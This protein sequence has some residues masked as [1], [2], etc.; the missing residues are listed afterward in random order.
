MMKIPRRDLLLAACLS[1]YLIS[2]GG[3]GSSP[4]DTTTPE[5]GSASPT[6]DAEQCAVDVAV[7]TPALTI[8]GGDALDFVGDRF[9]LASGDFNGDGRDDL[10]IGAPL[11][12]GL[13]N[14]RENSGEAYVILG[15]DSPPSSID[16]AQGDAALTV[17][18]EASG[19]H[20]G[21]TVAAGDVNGDGTDDVL[22]GARFASSD[23]RGAA[24]KAYVIFGGADLDSTV[25]TATGQQDVTVVGIDTGD[26]LTVALATGDVDGDGVSDIIMGA[27]GASGPEED[28]HQAGEVYVL[29]GS[30]R[31]E[32][33]I[34]L[35]Q[36]PPFFTVYGA[37]VNDGLPNHLA[38]GDLDG[39]GDDELIVGGPFA[40]GA[41]TEENAGR[42]Y[43]AAV[44]AAG[45]S[46]DLAAAK[47]FTTL[48]GGSIRD[49]LGFYVSA[50]DINSDGLD[51][52]IIGAR[53]ADGPNEIR[54]NIG[55][56]HILY[57]GADIGSTIDLAGDAVDAVMYGVDPGDSSGFS[58]GAGDFNGDGI[59]DV[60][61]GAPTADGCQNGRAESG[62][63]RIRFGRSDFPAISDFVLGQ[64]DLSFFGLESG[65]EAG[66]SLA[67]GDFNGDEIDDVFIGA[68]LAD[69]PGNARRD[70]GEVYVVLGERP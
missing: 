20:L 7:A 12:D 15:T 53:D 55:E 51:D 9:S 45:G 49:G 23:V 36:T 28:R 38:T 27:T 50:A 26:L 14:S 54:Q 69:G 8:F 31:L 41:L 63:V 66:F 37:A 67:S 64:Y 65:D 2:C 33:L 70:A 43:I 24:G 62:E 35:A 5:N 10:L 61:V 59:S 13:D 29:K 1:L 48:I 11:G 68:L 60:V 34:D 3:D 17:L 4:E 40:D 30:P 52:A 47:D 25:D 21:F 19:N 42:A 39:D 46:L 16:L 57:G 44:P 32:G 22:V 6:G 58:V 18:G 56:V